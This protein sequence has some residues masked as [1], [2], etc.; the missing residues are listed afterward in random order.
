MLTKNQNAKLKN[1]YILINFILCH[2]ALLQVFLFN[3]M[4]IKLDFYK[5]I[6]NLY[7]VKKCNF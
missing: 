2:E 5:K 3:Y 7:L 4:A 1:R 6:Y